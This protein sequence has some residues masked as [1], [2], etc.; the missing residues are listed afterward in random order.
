MVLGWLPSGCR[1]AVCY[2]PMEGRYS[3]EPRYKLRIYG[4]FMVRSFMLTHYIFGTREARRRRGSSGE[5][6]DLQ[7]NLTEMKTAS[8]FN[9]YPSKLPKTH[10]TV[11]ETFGGE[12]YL[13]DLCVN[14]GKDNRIILYVRF[15]TFSSL[16]F[17]V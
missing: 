8:L 1:E 13:K 16:Q 9:K 4:P 6:V 12:S 3:E 17:S 15:S 7:L 11:R 5:V 14:E 2:Q 10:K